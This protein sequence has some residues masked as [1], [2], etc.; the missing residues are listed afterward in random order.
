M[1]TPQKL[2]YQMQVVTNDHADPYLTDLFFFRLGQLDQARTGDIEHVVAP[3][4]ASYWLISVT[5][6]P[7]V[8]RL[9]GGVCGMV[10]EACDHDTGF[11]IHPF[12]LTFKPL[13]SP[14]D[15]VGD[16]LVG[17]IYY[18]ELGLW[19][20]TGIDLRDRAAIV[21]VQRVCRRDVGDGWRTDVQ[22]EGEEELI[23]R[24]VVISLV[25]RAETT[26]PP[27]NYTIDYTGCVDTWDW[28]VLNTWRLRNKRTGVL[29]ERRFYCRG[30]ALAFLVDVVKEQDARDGQ[31]YPSIGLAS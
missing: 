31:G 28:G 20:V 19:Q 18:H 15:V 30:E 7:A 22:A 1:S 2:Q 17:L 9:Y 12:E 6:R 3:A 8:E 4:P 26:V 5:A 10:D 16:N 14:R 21:R 29:Y 27:A 24:D 11:E 23:S 25:D 13:F